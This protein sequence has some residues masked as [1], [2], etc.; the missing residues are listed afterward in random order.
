MHVFLNNPFILY[1]IIIDIDNPSLYVGLQTK[2]KFACPVCGPKIKSRHSKSLGN[3]VF[4]EYRH[5]LDSKNHRHRTTEKHLFNGKQETA[6]KPQRMTPHLWKLQYNRNLQ[7]TYES[8]YIKCFEIFIYCVF[9][10][11]IDID[12][13]NFFINYH[14]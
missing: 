11:V 2:E 1:I 8:S 13:C 4:D 9:F 5:F 6:L 12:L 14:S 10:T 3:E 7:G